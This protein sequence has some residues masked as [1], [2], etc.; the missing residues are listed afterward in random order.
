MKHR[1]TIDG[2]EKDIDIR[3]MDEGFIVDRKLWEPPIKPTDHVEETEA[4]RIYAEF[5]RK[6]NRAIGSCAILAWEGDGVIGKM[7][8]TTKEA[9]D[10]FREAGGWICVDNNTTPGIIQR[11]SNGELARLWASESRTLTITC[12]NIGHFDTRYHGQG[13][14]SAMVEYLKEWARQNAWRRLEAPSCPDIVPFRCLG[15]N[16]MRRRWWMVPATRLELR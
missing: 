3:A 14:A 10:A 1:I 5:F 2:E 4:S 11:F 8:F 6:Q 13:L 12:F 16:L 7:R 9:Y 15:P